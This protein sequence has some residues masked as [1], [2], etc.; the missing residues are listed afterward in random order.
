MTTL[1]PFDAKQLKITKVAIIDGLGT[2]LPAIDVSGTYRDQ[3]LKASFGPELF[4]RDMEIEWDVIPPSVDAENMQDDAK[5]ANLM[6][7][8]NAIMDVPMY[9]DVLAQA[10]EAYEEAG[11]E[12]E[13]SDEEES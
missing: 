9:V 4:G 6:D 8:E 11:D 1:L 3:P 5:F 7:M 12:D 10:E 13:E 2:R